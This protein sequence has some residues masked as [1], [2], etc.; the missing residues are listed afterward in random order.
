MSK[1]KSVWLATADRPAY[2]ALDGDVGV[3][4][5]VVGGGI[6][7]LTTAL[8]VQRSGGRVAVVEADRGGG[9]TAG[10]TTGKITSQHTLA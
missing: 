8:P 5:V 10:Y 6:T 1:Q 3:D 7:G 2:P 9:G 4:A